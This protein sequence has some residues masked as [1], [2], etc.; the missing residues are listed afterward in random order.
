MPGE[1]HLLPNLRQGHSIEP[2][3]IPRP[4]DVIQVIINARAAFAFALP[5]GRQTANVSPIVI[6]PQERHVIRHAHTALVVSLHFLVKRPNLRHFRDVRVNYLT[7]QPALV[8]DNPFEQRDALR[9]CHGLIPV[10]AHSDGSDFFI[11]LR[12][13][14]SFGPERPQFLRIFGIVPGTLAIA[15]PL[16]LLPRAHHRLMVRGADHD[17]ILVSELRI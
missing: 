14:Q 12:S 15:G 6:A 3:V 9:L 4:A 10:A 17:A 1:V 13:L 11:I 16:P 7:D 2:F 5:V 8:A